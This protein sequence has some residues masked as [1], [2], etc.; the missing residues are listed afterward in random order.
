VSGVPGSGMA[1]TTVP[2][3]VM[4]KPARLP[5]GNGTEAG[6]H[7]PRAPR[8]TVQLPPAACC[9]LAVVAQI[10]Q[11]VPGGM[12]LTLASSSVPPGCGV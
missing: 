10:W 3:A 6:Y 9:P 5:A 4:S 1:T 2:P 12:P 11:R 7:A 8:V